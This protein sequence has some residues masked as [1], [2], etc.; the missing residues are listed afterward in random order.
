MGYRARTAKVA[1]LKLARVV[2]MYARRPQV[3]G[4]WPGGGGSGEHLNPRGTIVVIGEHVLHVD[5]RRCIS[6]ART[7]TSA[8]RGAR[9]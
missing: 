5:A 7:V 4:V 8:V 9:W 3:Q 1:G 6:R 2:D